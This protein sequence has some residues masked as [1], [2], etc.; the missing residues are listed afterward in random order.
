MGRILF[1]I[2]IRIVTVEDPSIIVS[3]SRLL[4]L[5]V[6]MVMYL[7]VG[8]DVMSW[9]DRIAERLFGSLIER[10]VQNAVKVIDDKWWSQIGGAAGPHDKNWGELQED[11]SDSLEAWRMN[12]LARRIV[13]LTTDYVV[14]DGITVTSGFSAVQEW[15]DEFWDHPMNHIDQRLYAW[16]DELTRSGELFIVVSVNPGSGMSYLRNIP[17]SAIDRIDTDPDD[18][19]REIQYH[20]LVDGTLEGRWWPSWLTAGVG[21]GQFVLHYTIN[22]PVGALRGEG[23][24][25]PILPWLRRYREW[26]EDRVRV[27]RLRN[28]FLW[29]VKLTNVTPGDL[30]RKQQQYKHAPSPGS[31]VVS[32]ENEEWLALSAQLQSSDAE[33]DGKALRLMVAAGAGIPL[34]FL[35]EGESATRA[36]AAEMGGPT[37]RHYKHRQ[38]AFSEILMDLVVVAAESAGIGVV[39]GLK[40][41]CV[42]PD[43]TRAD[44]LQLA[45]AL[46]EITGAIEKMLSLELIDQE[47][48]KVLVTKFAGGEEFNV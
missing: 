9:R 17:A 43:L 37:F 7:S 6:T 16:C 13:G 27:N 12:P 48:A 35:S 1:S 26:L 40:L 14:G 21:A 47:M 19:E 36:T 44:N 15:I 29:Q 18:L 28:S 11:L 38:L 32:D 45:Q 10:R 31:I 4:F 42:L 20:E 25:V 24:L 34:H 8:R 46:N 2:H 39:G 41:S 33:S 3:G 30:D 22:R 23:D 5:I